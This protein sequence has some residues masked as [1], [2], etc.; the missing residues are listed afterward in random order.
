MK[1]LKARLGA[2]LRKHVSTG[3]HE[4][5]EGIVERAVAVAHEEILD[6]IFS[7]DEGP[8]VVYIA[9]YNSHRD[10][11]YKDLIYIGVSTEAGLEKS[12]KL[13]QRAEP[14][15]RL[16]LLGKRHFDKRTKA[17]ERVRRFLDPAHFRNGWYR[18][19][20]VDFYDVCDLAR[21]ALA[22]GTRMPDKNRYVP[23]SRRGR[24]APIIVSSD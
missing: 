24:A 15:L 5:V 16:N 23:P 2:K 17:V 11:R 8:G 22:T 3:R 18:I 6:E 4:I 19:K 10:N 1:K 21:N 7:Y 9:N 13:A 12:L 14:V 20:P